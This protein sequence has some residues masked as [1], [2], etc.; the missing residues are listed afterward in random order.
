VLFPLSGRTVHGII[1]RVILR[2][3]EVWIV[4]YKTHRISPDAAPELSRHYGEQMALYAEG[5]RRLW[6]QRRIRS[7]ILFTA[8]GVL[9]ELEMEHE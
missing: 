8:P 9:E 2:D 7:F 6:P 3:D 4:D 5:A 1:D